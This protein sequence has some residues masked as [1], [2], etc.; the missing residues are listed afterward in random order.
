MLSDMLNRLYNEHKYIFILGDF[1]V[2]LSPH[3]ESSIAMEDFKNIYKY[4]IYI[5]KATRVVDN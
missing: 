5:N 2:D 3:A 4:N 1:N